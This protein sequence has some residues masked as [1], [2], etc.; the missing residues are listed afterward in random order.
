MNN[1][2]DLFS[3]SAT[4]TIPPEQLGDWTRPSYPLAEFA[5][6]LEAAELGLHGLPG[7]PTRTA[8]EIALDFCQDEVSKTA[9]TWPDGHLQSVN[10]RLSSFTFQALVL[11]I[12]DARQLGGEVRRRFTGTHVNW[13]IF[14][15]GIGTL[16]LWNYRCGPSGSFAPYRDNAMRDSYRDGAAMMFLPFE[17]GLEVYHAQKVAMSPSDPV[18]VPTLS[19]GGKLWTCAGS[20]G[21]TC[22]YFWSILPADEWAGPKHTYSQRVRAYDSGE[23]ERGDSRGQLVK[24]RGQLAVLHEPAFNLGSKRMQE[25]AERQEPVFM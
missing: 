18:E 21:C 23:I 25:I 20:Y 6:L 12:R 22:Q 4:A 19:H 2:F 9:E 3:A 8:Y 5:R 14:F 24:V 11:A 1:S 17:A 7:G 16:S 13:H 10:F 15:D